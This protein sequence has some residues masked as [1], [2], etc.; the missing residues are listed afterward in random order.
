MNG[1]ATM[2]RMDCLPVDALREICLRADYV[3]LCVAEVAVP[4]ISRAI[5]GR[6]FWTNKLTRDYPAIASFVEP[7]DDP[8]E[9]YDHAYELVGVRVADLARCLR[10]PSCVLHIVDHTVMPLMRLLFAGG[11]DF[12]NAINRIA[13]RGNLPLLEWL[14]ARGVV[15]DS[16]GANVAAAEGQLEVLEW[17]EKR[18]VLPT[19]LGANLAVA[20]GCLPALEWMEARGILPHRDIA[21]WTVDNEHLA[22]LKWLEARG[23]MSTAANLEVA[24]GHADILEWLTAWCC[25]L[26]MT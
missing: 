19:M 24:N 1:R 4:A 13:E 17:L 25:R 12:N 7:D 16:S 26:N 9:T 15:A 2:I 5:A 18:Q 8:R 23:F 6:H 14:E 10:A 3:D 22:V 11:Y 21:N 20:S